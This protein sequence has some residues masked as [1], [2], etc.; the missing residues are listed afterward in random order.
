M[1]NWG[2]GKPQKA[3]KTQK[4]AEDQR[5][6]ESVQLRLGRFLRFLSFLWFPLSGLCELCE[7]QLVGI[8]DHDHDFRACPMGDACVA[9]T[10]PPIHCLQLRLLRPFH[11][12]LSSTFPLS[13]SLFPLLASGRLRIPPKCNTGNRARAGTIRFPRWRVR[14]RTGR[15]I[16]SRP[17]SRTCRRLSTPG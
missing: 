8:F 9:P 12:P 13:S 3:Q 10:K 1:R 7:R 6:G 11:F 4:G 17:R 2:E 15:P 5:K 14:R 16:Y